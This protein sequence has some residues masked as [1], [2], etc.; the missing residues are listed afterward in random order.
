R[1]RTTSR[2]THV[3]P[4]FSISSRNEGQLVSVPSLHFVAAPPYQVQ[5]PHLMSAGVLHEFRGHEQPRV[6]ANHGDWFI[7]SV[8]ALHERL[9]LRDHSGIGGS[10][11]QRSFADMT[12]RRELASH[13]DILRQRLAPVAIPHAVFCSGRCRGRT[14]QLTVSPPNTPITRAPK[15]HNLKV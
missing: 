13:G 12:D 8:T 1:S 2:S 9:C 6:V 4:A 5:A 11:H 3:P 15:L 14:Y 7:V 10:S